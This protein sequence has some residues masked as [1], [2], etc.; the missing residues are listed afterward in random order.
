[1]TIS[2]G[3]SIDR[4][5]RSGECDRWDG[6]PFQGIGLRVRIR[7]QAQAR[8]AH[9]RAG[10]AGVPELP[11]WPPVELLALLDSLEDDQFGIIDPRA[12]WEF[13]GPLGGDDKSQAGAEPEA[14][15][16]PGAV[17]DG[18]TRKSGGEPTDP[19]AESRSG[20]P[21]RPGC[22]DFGRG[23]R[24]V[25]PPRR[26]AGA[27]GRR[28]SRTSRDIAGLPRSRESGWIGSEARDPTRANRSRSPEAGHVGYV[29]R[30]RAPAAGEPSGVFGVP[31][32]G[33][34]P[35]PGSPG[36]AVG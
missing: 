2:N 30:K 36:A 31:P 33:F 20:R 24:W 26:R 6:E 18:L 17:D 19:D 29:R 13:C 11:G 10:D 32:A 28:R 25:R 34:A 21:V 12:L 9:P 23:W 8:Q 27:R 7:I 1:M 14:E 15:L 16:D 22:D 4:G 35:G 5:G 3:T